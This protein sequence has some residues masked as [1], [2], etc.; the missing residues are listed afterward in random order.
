MM[1]KMIATLL[2]AAVLLTAVA[3]AQGYTSER[4][5]LTY[6]ENAF[7]IT[8]DDKTEDEHLLILTGKN[9]AWGN[10]YIRFYTHMQADDED[11]PTAE[12]VNEAIPDAQATEGEW[13]GFSNAV[14]YENGDESV[15]LVPLTTG[16]LLTVG[17]HVDA[18][19]DED[20]AMERDDQIS[21][22]L[23]SLKVIPETDD[24]A[25]GN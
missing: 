18:I 10:A 3:F 25:T 8:M 4:I 19:E 9:E 20:A 14:M 5:A 1:K 11:V 17:V 7:E 22:V 2:L 23:D 15:F 13:N 21:A 16:E 12:S 6:D 24:D